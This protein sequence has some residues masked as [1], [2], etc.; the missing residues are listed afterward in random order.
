MITD[1]N[2]DYND[3]NLNDIKFLKDIAV[4][5][6]SRYW[7][8][9][10]FCLFESINNI[11]YIIYTK[12]NKSI[13]LFNLI[14]GKKLNEIKNAHENY[15][16]NF[17]YYLDKIHL[18]DLILSIS[19]DDNNIKLW[20][21]KN[22]DCLLEIKNVNKDGYLYSAYFLNNNNQNYIITSNCNF[23]NRN[24]EL[25]KVFDFNGNKIKE[26]ENSNDRTY[27][28]DSFFDKK[29]CKNYII[30]GCCGYVKSYDFNTNK[31]YHKYNDNDKIF[32][33]SII[34]NN[35]EEI[36]KLIESSCSGNVRIWNFHSGQLLNKIKVI[37][38][39]IYGI[40]L[41]D[42][43][44]LFVGCKSGEIKL[45]DLNKDIII[46]DLI[47]HNDKVLTIKKIKHPKYG[48]YLISQNSNNSCIKMWEIKK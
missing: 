5:S 29:L 6:F 22:L 45:I 27:I 31:I 28:I 25:I 10:T 35:L 8:D 13:I 30:S 1:I 46:K 24:Y 15:I 48:H 9:N 18:R 23:A 11:I 3:D 14:S 21:I 33:N 2:K 20:N 7:L 40:C 17:R 44:F 47:G 38:D 41:W 34:I 36:V 43:N 4:D 39:W 12:E 42:N 26:M 16:T 19:C 32:H 37:D